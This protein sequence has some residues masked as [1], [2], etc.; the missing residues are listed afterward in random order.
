[1]S[2]IKRKCAGCG[3]IRN[4]KELIKL[5]RRN[6]DGKVI[7]NPDTKTFGRSAYLCYNHDCI[8]KALV[9][10]RLSKVLKAPINEELKGQLIDR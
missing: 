7:L 3:Q 5:T 6:T 8:K 10:N 4:R 9:K 2:E 1:M